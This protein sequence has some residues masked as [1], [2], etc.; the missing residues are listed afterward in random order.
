MPGALLISVV[1]L[2]RDEWAFFRKG[3]QHP[4]TYS[5][6]VVLLD[7]QENVGQVTV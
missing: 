1:K 5:R 2:K 7:V 6:E 3:G 4:G